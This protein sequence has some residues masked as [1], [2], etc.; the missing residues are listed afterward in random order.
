MICKIK[1]YKLIINQFSDLYVKN[2]LCYFGQFE[3]EVAKLLSGTDFVLYFISMYSAILRKFIF[4]RFI[5][6]FVTVI[7]QKWWVRNFKS[8]MNAQIKESKII[9]NNLSMHNNFNHL[10]IKTV[11]YC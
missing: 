4:K 11:N 6:Y 8:K 1:K 10:K 9:N 2:Y 5:N 3:G 7:I